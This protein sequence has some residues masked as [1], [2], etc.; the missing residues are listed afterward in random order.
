MTAFTA[1]QTAE[2][3]AIIARLAREI[4]YEHYVPLIGRAQVDYMVDKFQ[5]TTAIREQIAAGYEYYWVREAN[6]AVGY[7]GLQPQPECLFVSKFYLLARVRGTGLGRVAIEFIERRSRE[8]G[9]SRLALTV[10]K[11]NPSLQVYLR[12]GFENCGSVITEIGNG[13][14]MDDYRME[15]EV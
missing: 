5:S 3:I 7:L 11:H 15:K 9:L 1:V 14:V 2:D 13:Y 4:W 8:H 10:H 12:L 6:E